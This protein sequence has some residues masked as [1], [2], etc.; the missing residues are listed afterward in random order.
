M[1]N[2]KR[3]LIEFVAILV[4]G[5][6]TYLLFI[7]APSLMN[8]FFVAFIGGSLTKSVARAIEYSGDKKIEE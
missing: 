5:Y 6:L 3:N 1:K 8:Q 7:G 4:C 2:F